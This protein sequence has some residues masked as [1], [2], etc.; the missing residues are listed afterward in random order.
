[1]TGEITLRGEVL[2]VGGIKEKL[3][4]AHRG[5][6][7]SVIIPMEN[8]KDLKEIPDNI[9]KDLDVKPVRWIEEVFTYALNGY[10]AKLPRKAKTKMKTLVG[11]TKRKIS[12][13]D[14][15]RAH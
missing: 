6:I 8:V 1:M 2:P 3:L 15:D 9:K 10:P 5:G 11:G 12:K 14:R 4:A 13:G 7:K